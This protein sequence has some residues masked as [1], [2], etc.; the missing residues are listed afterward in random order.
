MTA[1]YNNVGLWDIR[2]Y[3]YD[4]DGNPLK[5]SEGEVVVFDAPDWLT[6]LVDMGE[7]EDIDAEDLDE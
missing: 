4:D 6:D 5:N 7:V 3:K 2:L 1:K